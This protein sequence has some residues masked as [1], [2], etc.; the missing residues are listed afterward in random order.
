MLVPATNDLIFCRLDLT[1]PCLVIAGG[2]AGG[3]VEEE[4][5]GYMPS[6][7]PRDA[8]ARDALRKSAPNAFG[9]NHQ[10]AAAEGELVWRGERA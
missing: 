10:S 7:G 8:S 6:F 3:E 9:G 5:S 1:L 4:P 2:E